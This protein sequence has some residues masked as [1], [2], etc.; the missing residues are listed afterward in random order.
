MKIL[1]LDEQG[2][3][4]DAVGLYLERVEPDLEI[5]S[6]NNL[7]NGFA[8]ARK[9]NDIV[10]TLINIQKIQPTGIRV[11]EEYKAML[12]DIP[13]GIISEPMTMDI[14]LRAMEMSAVG[15]FPKNMRAEAFVQALRFVL[16]GEKFLPCDIGDAEKVAYYRPSYSS[17]VNEG[18]KQNIFSYHGLSAQR[19]QGV[20]ARYDG[21]GDI[22]NDTLSRLS[23]KEI[24]TLRFIGKSM[25]NKQIAS[26]L[27]VKEVTTKQHVSSMLRKLELDNRTQLAM[28]A[29]DCNLI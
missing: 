5:L 7:E 21:V 12:P 1:I 8:I 11:V 10:L 24:Q 19:R 14:V 25:T 3:L 22:S 27:N 13:F 26:E 29:R 28:V 16:S 2:I 20:E 18:A 9:H 23:A 4:L 15:Y 6:A 17:A